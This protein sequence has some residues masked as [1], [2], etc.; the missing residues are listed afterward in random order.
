MGLALARPYPAGARLLQLLGQAPAVVV[1]AVLGVLRRV[2]VVGLHKPALDLLLQ[3]FALG[4]QP[5]VAHRLVLRGV[6]AHLGAV[7]ADM[8][9]PHEPRLPAELQHLREQALERLLEPLAE[10][11]IVWKSG[12][13]QSVR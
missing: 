8:A 6:R 11:E 3:G 5:L 1:G 2:L 4:Q 13:A 10:L 9:Q 7:Q 12:R